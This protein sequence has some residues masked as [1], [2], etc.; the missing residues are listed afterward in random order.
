M[1][2]LGELKK[3][4]KI[5]NYIETTICTS[6]T[7]T[8]TFAKFPSLSLWEELVDLSKY[9]IR[10]D[11]D[12]GKSSVPPV[13]QNQGYKQTDKKQLNKNVLDINCLFFYS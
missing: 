12:R 11:Y 6:E 8:R 7:R 1:L 10:N 2:I 9:T 5:D 13:F 4:K 3:R